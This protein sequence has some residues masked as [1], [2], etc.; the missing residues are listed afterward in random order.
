MTAMPL[1]GTVT[2]VLGLVAALALATC[3]AVIAVQLWQA[4]KALAEVDA[5][6]TTLPPGLAGLEPAMDTINAA[7]AR[8]ADAAGR[9]VSARR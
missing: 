5:A 7:L 3:V 1:A 4:S 2:I 9:P 8:L 6:L